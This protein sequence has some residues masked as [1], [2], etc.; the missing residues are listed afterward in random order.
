MPFGSVVSEIVKTGHPVK[1]VVESGAVHF[2]V[3]SGNRGSRGKISFLRVCP[4]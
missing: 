4:E 2:M 3:A 1:S